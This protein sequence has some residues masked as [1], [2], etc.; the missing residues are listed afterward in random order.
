MQDGIMSHRRRVEKD[1]LEEIQHERRVAFSINLKTNHLVF[2]ST[3][4]D[5]LEDMAVINETR[6]KDTKQV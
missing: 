6:N 5:G 1:L 4:A 3:F 2:I